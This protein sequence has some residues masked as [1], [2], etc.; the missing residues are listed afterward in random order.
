MTGNGVL[1]ILVF[2]AVL[3]A[4]GIPLGAYMARVYQGEARIAQK[5]LGP[6]ERLV[7]R[8]GGVRPDEDMSW[9]RYALAFMIFHLFGLV[10]GV[11]LMRLQ[12][13]LP[14]NPAELGNVD[15]NV[16]W[17]TA[18][19]FVTNTNWQANGGGF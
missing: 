18:I 16:A 19:S 7:Y 13:G 10:L 3:T 17:N 5:V 6:V 14:L 8:F 11:L 9:K 1:Q 12:A 2:F 15:A 4:V